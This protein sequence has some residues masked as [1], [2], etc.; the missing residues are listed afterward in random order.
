MP[1]LTDRE[2]DVLEWM[3]EGLTNKEIAQTI[4]IS[5]AGVK[6][7]LHAIYHKL[8]ITGSRQ[9]FPKLEQIRVEIFRQTKD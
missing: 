1:E 9:L 5:V 8:E 4:G 2:K 7:S 6:N 3:L